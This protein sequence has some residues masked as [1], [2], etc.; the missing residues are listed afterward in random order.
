MLIRHGTNVVNIA[1]ALAI[2]QSKFADTLSTHLSND[3][4]RVIYI[5]NISLSPTNVSVYIHIS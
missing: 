5:Y 3:L 2:C 4:F 1:Q